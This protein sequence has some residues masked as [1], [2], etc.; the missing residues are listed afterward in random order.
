MSRWGKRVEGNLVDSD[1]HPAAWS[2]RQL[3]VLNV[4]IYIPAL[5]KHMATHSSL[6][7]WKIPWMEKPGGA[8]SMGSQRAE[9]DWVTNTHTCLCVCMCICVCMLSHLSCVW[10]W[11]PMDCSPPGSS[12]HGNLRQEHWSGLLC[13]LPGDRPDSGID[14]ESLTSTYLG[15][16]VLYHWR[17]LGSPWAS[18]NVF[19]FVCVYMY[20]YAESVS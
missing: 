9:H 5:E 15:R 4:Y 7:A 10:L 1:L 14:L 18:M 3:W 11:D 12:V 8:Q 19:T 17:N 20:P 13:P 2:S 6:F 16:W